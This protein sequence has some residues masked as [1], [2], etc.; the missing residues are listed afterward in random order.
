MAIRGEIY[1]EVAFPQG[2]LDDKRLYISQPATPS[3]LEVTITGR[4][5]PTSLARF[6][7][8][9]TP[10]SRGNQQHGT[11][12]LTVTVKPGQTR[13]IPGSFLVGLKYG[14]V[15]FAIRLRPGQRIAGVRKQPFVLFK[16]KQGEPVVYLLYGP[17]V[18]EV[19]TDASL[20][21]EP[22]VTSAIDA[23]FT[24]QFARLIKVT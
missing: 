21:V 22:E 9:G 15:G 23:E 14:N 13:F 3:R 10:V 2:Y 20:K 12:G 18:D 11:T 7:P 16:N 8:P 17:S 1:R 24:R 5:R 19:V 4:D 6:T